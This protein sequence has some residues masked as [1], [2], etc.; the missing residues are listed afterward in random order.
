MGGT[1]NL[2]HSFDTL[3]VMKSNDNYDSL[4]AY[5]LKFMIHSRYSF[6]S[7]VFKNHLYVVGGYT[8]SLQMLKKCEIYTIES[9][10]W[11]SLPNLPVNAGLGSLVVSND[12][13][14]FIN[15]TVDDTKI[16]NKNS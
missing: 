12:V 13:L 5:E 8:K 14:Y 3:T 10:K 7:T 9:N 4:S 15:P 11:R 1:Y 6:A 16:K 2:N